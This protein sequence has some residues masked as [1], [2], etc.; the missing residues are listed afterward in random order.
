MR[1]KSLSLAGCPAFLGGLGGFDGGAAKMFMSQSNP[2]A[3]YRV[4]PGVYRLPQPP[5][6]IPPGVYRIP[7]VVYRVPPTGGNNPHTG[8]KGWQTG[9]NNPP[10]GGNV[11]L[12]GGTHYTS[13][14]WPMQC[15]GRNRC[16]WPFCAPVAAAPHQRL[17]TGCLR[18]GV[19]P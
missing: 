18:L 3:V 15:A 10:A 8:G 19:E 7:P 17:L 6:R 2:P 12:V 14:G 4:P 1:A 11:P 5:R 9:G 16:H 13:V